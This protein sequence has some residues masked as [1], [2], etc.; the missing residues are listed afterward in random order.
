M[1]SRT[2]RVIGLAAATAAAAGA[3][4]GAAAVERSARERRSLPSLDP[5]RGY[6]QRPDAVL[7]VVASDGVHLHVEIDEPDAGGP[8]RP[9]VVLAHGF[10]LSCDSWVF[11][12]RALVAAGHR[13][14][15]WDQRGHG[16]SDA[17][18]DAH[19]SIEQLAHDL[20]AVIETVCPEGDLVLIGHSMGGMTLMALAHHH[21]TVIL[22]R[23]LATSFVATSAGGAGLTDLD[24]GPFVG[25]VLGRFG[26]AILGRLNRYAEPLHRLRRFGR[27]VEDAL[28]E[29]YSFDSPVSQQL[30]RFCADM[31]FATS[32]STMAQFLVAIQKHDE[33]G[34]LSV[35]SGIETLVINGRGDLLTPPEHSDALVEHLP[36][37]EHVVV[38]EAGHLIQLEHPD[39][40]NQQ[41][42]MLID[43]A[44]AAR[45]GAVG[46]A[47]KPRVR[48]V[49]TDV[50]RRRQVARAKSGA[51]VR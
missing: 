33:T 44:L 13:V 48:R 46:V 14:V 19:A 50:A 31:I 9:T 26:P 17:G 7:T 12:R 39:L 15:S 34:S 41:L 20:H 49:I 21:P 32:F 27:N 18:D 22:D 38:E 35:F 51:G 47:R 10:T 11:Q 8:V 4:A 3:A 29:R 1:A 28:V 5:R 25:Q 43:R 45:A 36:G 37:A 30:V 42:L 6:V 16:R 2:G 40:V 23:V 24:F